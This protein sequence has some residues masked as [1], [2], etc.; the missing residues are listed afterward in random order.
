MSHKQASDDKVRR[1]WEDEEGNVM[2]VKTC[3]ELEKLTICG[4]WLRERAKSASASTAGEEA[5]A[6]QEMVVHRQ[7][8]QIKLVAGT[9]HTRF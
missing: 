7:K 2:P 6:S 5:A 4:L 9:K 1:K 8:T 3:A